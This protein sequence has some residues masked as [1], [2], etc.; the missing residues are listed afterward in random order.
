M[1][2]ATAPTAAAPAAPA[3][4]PASKRPR[5]A[6]SIQSL[7]DKHAEAVG[8][9][10]YNTL[11]MLAKEVSELEDERDALVTELCHLE[12]PEGLT[13]VAERLFRLSNNFT[14]NLLNVRI[15]T[16]QNLGLTLI[17]TARNNGNV[18]D[19]SFPPSMEGMVDNTH[20]FRSYGKYLLYIGDGTFG[21][22][23]LIDFEKDRLRISEAPGELHD[24][25]GG[26]Y[27]E[28]KLM[29]DG[30]DTGVEWTTAAEPVEAADN[31]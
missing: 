13:I 25:Q 6:H 8:S 9:G 30:D 15:W 19:W 14:S 4:P 27:E 28:G 24:G 26:L 1:A 12:E 31:E 3:A 10:D 20:V 23:C 7:V 18:P 16:D 21:H 11:S 5:L 29:I 22:E 17:P 2:D